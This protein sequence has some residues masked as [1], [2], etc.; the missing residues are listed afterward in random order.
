MDGGEAFRIM[1]E[2]RTGGKAAKRKHWF[3]HTELPVH[4]DTLRRRVTRAAGNGETSCAYS[5]AMPGPRE[6][7]GLELLRRVQS[8]FPQMVVTASTTNGTYCLCRYPTLFAHV[9]LNWGNRAA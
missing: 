8:A 4:I 7:V 5:F 3:L 9:T 2:S 1:T 6:E